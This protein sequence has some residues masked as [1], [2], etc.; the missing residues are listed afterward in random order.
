MYTN[1]GDQ[2]E[3][4]KQYINRCSKPNNTNSGGTSGKRPNLC[5][6]TGSKARIMEENTG[7][8]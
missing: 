4:P 8:V 3:T 5:R 7:Q 1:I 6:D 2:D